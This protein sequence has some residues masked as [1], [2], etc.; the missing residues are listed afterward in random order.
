MSK[1]MT[2]LQQALSSAATAQTARPEKPPSQLEPAPDSRTK[3]QTRA[4]SRQGKENI[5]TW[6]YPDFKKSLRLVQLRKPGK[7]Y[8]D[9][10]VAEAL[11]DLFLKYNVPTVNHD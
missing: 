4:P 6:L 2:G 8:L 11:N 7:V 1:K 5:G 9:D 10:L 3:A